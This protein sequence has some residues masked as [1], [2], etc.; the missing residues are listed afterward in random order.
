MWPRA[1]GQTSPSSVAIGKGAQG[2][3]ITG[4]TMTI[5][6]VRSDY[7]T[8]ALSV[9]GC[10]ERLDNAREIFLFYLV[11]GAEMQLSK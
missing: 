1:V 11:C 6:H 7:T 8:F 5:S 3:V 4:D 2:Q 9:Q 10:R